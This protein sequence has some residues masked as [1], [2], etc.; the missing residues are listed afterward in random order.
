MY[1]SYGYHDKRV[2]DNRGRYS[3]CVILAHS[4]D[5][6]RTTG[7]PVGTP[8]YKERQDVT[9]I[10]GNMELGNSGFHG[11]K[12]FLRKWSATELRFVSPVVGSEVYRI[13]VSRCA[14]L[15]ACPGRPRLGP[16]LATT[17]IYHCHTQTRYLD[18]NDE[19]IWFLISSHLLLSIAHREFLW[20]NQY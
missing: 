10:I 1:S 11:R 4:Y 20:Y 8:T 9:I 16:T 12:K 15:L 3:N 19:Y 5:Q 18:N 7:K 2:T 13:S 6:G 14:Q 17:R